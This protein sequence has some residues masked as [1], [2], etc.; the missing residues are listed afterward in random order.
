[1]AW[2]HRRAGLLEVENGGDSFSARAARVAAPPMSPSKAL[3]MG[4]PVHRGL[5]CGLVGAAKL[6]LLAKLT[7]NRSP[8][9]KP[10]HP[11]GISSQTA[12]LSRLRSQRQTLESGR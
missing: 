12:A 3:V 5:N 4:L 11:T 2:P 8:D 10:H 1:M 6:D 7:G 9:L